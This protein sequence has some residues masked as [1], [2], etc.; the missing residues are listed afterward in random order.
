MKRETDLHF[1]EL[2]HRVENVRR[3]GVPLGER[4]ARLF[5]S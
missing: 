4:V 1:G 5:V 3:P 2:E